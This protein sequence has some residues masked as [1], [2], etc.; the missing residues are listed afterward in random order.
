M[1]PL[2]R[3]ELGEYTLLPLVDDEW[4]PV[5]PHQWVLPGRRVLTTEEVC[6][7]AAERGLSVSILTA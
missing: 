4:E 1:P 5:F 6:A 2:P 3:L 7:L